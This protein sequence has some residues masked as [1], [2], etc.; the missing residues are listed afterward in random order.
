[1]TKY[2]FVH[3]Y[4]FEK[5][6]EIFN[7]VI[8]Q[9]ELEK[10]QNGKTQQ[11]EQKQAPSIRHKRK[12][13]AVLLLRQNIERNL[14]Y[15]KHCLKPLL[16]E[17]IEDAFS[18]ENNQTDDE[19]KE[20]D[21]KDNQLNVKDDKEKL[22]NIKF[23]I[24]KRIKSKSFWQNRKPGGLWRRS[25]E[26]PDLKNLKTLEIDDLKLP[27]FE[28][29]VHHFFVEPDRRMFIRNSKL[30]D[31]SSYFYRIFI[32]EFRDVP[33]FWNYNHDVLLLELVFR[34]GIDTVKIIQNIDASVTNYKK[35]VMVTEGTY[36]ADEISSHPL[37]GFQTW[38]KTE[39]NILHRLK[40]V[41][42]TIVNALEKNLNQN[43]SI[44]SKYQRDSHLKFVA[45]SDWKYS[46]KAMQQDDDD[47]NDDDLDDNHKFEQTDKHRI[48]RK[49]KVDPYIPRDI[50]TELFASFQACDIMRF[51]EPLTRFMIDKLNREPNLKESQYHVLG[52]LFYSLPDPLIVQILM[53]SIQ[54][55]QRAKPEALRDL[56]LQIEAGSTVQFLCVFCFRFGIY[57]I[58]IY[59]K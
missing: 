51:G 14:N 15:I 35:R 24:K 6:K 36:F 25:K 12:W 23:Y 54:I 50:E 45:R 28:N 27:L 55:L 34:N 43:Y 56:C 7:A 16:N 8:K 3:E 17:L 13:S 44:F 49:I 33:N 41:T 5:V 38:C 37:Y 39:V 19:N 57:R 42:N 9:K 40:Y 29:F 4:S 30:G 1:M 26:K 58:M 48:A 53:E 20:N 18:I 52:L 59:K 46:D 22:K 2:N 47:K 32:D 31:Y 10:N 11:Q 21:I